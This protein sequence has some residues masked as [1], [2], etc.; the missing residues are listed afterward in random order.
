MPVPTWYNQDGAIHTGFCIV[1]DLT[2]KPEQF[3]E[4]SLRVFTWVLGY[5]LFCVLIWLDHIGL[6]VATLV[7]LSFLGMDR[8]DEKAARFVRPWATARFIPE[9]VK[10]FTTWAPL[11]I[12]FYIPAGADWDWAWTHGEAI[13]QSSHGIVQELLALPGTQLAWLAIAAGA[14]VSLASFALRRATA[15]R[16]V[17]YT[18]AGALYAVTAKASGELQNRLASPEYDVTRRSY[19]ALDSAGCALFLTECTPLAPREEPAGSAEPEHPGQTDLT[20]SVRSTENARSTSAAWPVVG[21]YPEEFFIK[22][23][24]EGDGHTIRITNQ[25]HEIRATVTIRLPNDAGAVAA[26]L[27]EITLE[28]LGNRPRVLRVV[29]Y[30]EWVLA[31]PGADRGHTQYNRLFPEMSYEPELNAVLALHRATKKLGVL[32]ADRPPRG[33]LTS[34]LDFVGRAGS[35]WSPGCLEMP[36]DASSFIEPHRAEACPTFDPIGSLLV[37]IPLEARGSGSLRLL[38]GCADDKDEAA[39]WVRRYV[40]PSVAAAWHEPAPRQPRIGHGRIPPGTPQPYCEFADGG[41]R[42]RVHTPLTPRPFDHAMANALGHVLSVTNRGLHS[43]ASVN[44]QQNRITPDWADTATS[45]LPSEAFYLYDPESGQWFS[46]T[47]LPLRDNEA[48]YSAEFGVDGTATFRMERPE[49][50]TELTAFVPPHEPAGVYLLTVTNRGPGVRRLRLAPYFEI[51][52]AQNPENAG[53]LKVDCD[54]ASGALFFEN[55]RNTF[56]SG[57][58]FAAMS[59]RVERVATRRGDFFGPSRSLAHP[60]FVVSDYTA[61]N[62]LVAHGTAENEREAARQAFAAGVDMDMQSGAYDRY[63]GQLVAEGKISQTQIDEAVR[64]ILRLKFMLGLFDDPYRYCDRER[65]K[66]LL[67]AA[68]HR[69][70]TYDMACRS[71]VLLKNGKHTLPLKPGA[72]IALI[73]PLAQARQDLLGS[74]SGDGDAERVEPVLAAV[75]R[76]NGGGR[77]S[78]ARGCDVDSRDRSGFAAAVKAASQAEVVVMVLGESQ[79][80]SGEAASRTRIGLPGVQSELVEAIAAAGKPLVLV[81][82]NGRP[83]ALEKE[84]TL[85]DAILEAWYPG[86]EGARAVADMLFGKRVPSGKLPVTFPRCLGQ[87]PIYYGMKRTGRPMD[88]AKPGEEYVSRYLDCANDP[89]YPFGFGLSY[90]TFAY[91]DLK[92]SAERLRPGEQL[93]ATATVRNTGSCDGAEVVQLYI[94]NLVGS[95][96]RPVRE[97]KGFRRIELRA[98]ESRAV[99]FSIGQEELRSLRGDMTWGTEP[100]KYRV[101]VGPNSRDLLS[102]PFELVAAAKCP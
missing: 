39:D 100:G 101:L 21:N 40:Q 1:N 58:A 41:R 71:M 76:T 68:A 42:L 82:M 28:N 10:R 70:A 96:T 3:R 98:G 18:L 99:T 89:L 46:P 54:R 79:D 66:R 91:S 74:W 9:G 84:S 57:P 50:A 34:R 83:L 19:E 5:D 90:T 4:W 55:R 23:R 73:G 6:R 61:I 77:V 12:P 48:A 2:M 26:E 59:H 32:A 47:Y 49:I 86:S 56:R 16:P 65:E 78:F 24:I 7:N 80:M 45:E 13:Q 14:A 75:T 81:L 11:L 94:Q 60:M 17:E 27:W 22:S 33:F 67:G 85:A 8:L 97:L 51:A 63:L 25:S 72:R 62:E 38:I 87:T 30:L 53:P 95:V 36:F 52:L 29:P 37:D 69:E 93:T 43:S 102:A 88:P 31:T 92:L 64:R 35:V 15:A 44:A 20:R